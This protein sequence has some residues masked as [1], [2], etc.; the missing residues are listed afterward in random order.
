MHSEKIQITHTKCV[1]FFLPMLYINKSLFRSVFL[2]LFFFILFNHQIQMTHKINPSWGSTGWEQSQ[3]L[4]LLTQGGKETKIR[5]PHST[6]TVDKQTGRVRPLT[7]YH[8]SMFLTEGR[9]YVFAT[10]GLHTQNF[11]FLKI[12]SIILY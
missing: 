9:W 7:N 8:K 12:Q 10:K 6:H 1:Y 2:I 4:N 5:R 11:F 3:S